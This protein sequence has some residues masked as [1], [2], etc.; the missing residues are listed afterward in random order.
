MSTPDLV[1][2]DSVDPS[3]L[4]KINNQVLFFFSEKNHKKW[5]IIPLAIKNEFSLCFKEILKLNFD[6]S[7]LVLSE[8]GF[9]D[10]PE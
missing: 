8:S 3:S 9:A 2:H 5:G 1:S 7:K 6:S 10:N 4:L